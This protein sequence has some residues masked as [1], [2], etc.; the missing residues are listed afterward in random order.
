MVHVI[1]KNANI[2]F[3]AQK[4]KLCKALLTVNFVGEEM[5]GT[6]GY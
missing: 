3:G 4:L 5:G 6:V 2:L 1:L